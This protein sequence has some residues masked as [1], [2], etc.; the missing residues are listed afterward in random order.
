MPKKS[1]DTESDDSVD[2]RLAERKRL[3]EEQAAKP[4]E[5]L[6]VS[7]G[8][9]SDDSDDSST[10]LADLVPKKGKVASTNPAAKTKVARAKKTP[11]AKIARKKKDSETPEVSSAPSSTRKILNMY[12]NPRTTR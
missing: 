2:Q 9:N 3:R 7:S 4:K 10:P 5:T 1:G 6:E 12:P 8:S 11:K